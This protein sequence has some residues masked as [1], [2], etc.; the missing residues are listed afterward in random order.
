MELRVE[1]HHIVDVLHLAGRLDLVSSS[2]L[3]DTIRQRLADRR[4]LIVLNLERVDFINTSGLGALISA[5]RDV[6]LANGRLVLCGLAPYVDELLEITGLKKVFETYATTQ[7][8]LASFRGV[9]ART[10]AVSR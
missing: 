7:A 2:T 10:A 9:A 6:R 4:T 3:K 1:T 5:L 8:A